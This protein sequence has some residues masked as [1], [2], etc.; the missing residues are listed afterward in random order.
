[1]PNWYSTLS[2]NEK[3]TFWA[4]YGGW[5]LDALD[6]QMLPLVLP[7]IMK[8]WRVSHTGAGSIVSASL[9][10]S[11]LGGWLGGALADRYGRV[12]VLQI[13]VI[14][15]SLFSLLAAVAQSPAQLA[16]FK[17]LQGLG[18]GGE[19][20]V[21]AVLVAEVFRPQHRGKALGTIQSGWAVGW[22]ISVLLFTILSSF[23][24]Q[25]IC[26]RV[27]FVLGVLPAL[28]VL[29]IQRSIPEP[30]NSAA[31]LTDDGSSNR[32]T[33]R[34]TMFHIFS[35]AN[36]RITLIGALL[37]L[38]AHGGYYAFTTWLP[39]Y[40]MIERHIPLPAAGAYLGMIIVSFWCGCIGAAYL[41]DK[42]GRRYTI[43]LFSLG[44][45]A[46][47]T[48]YLLMHAT[49][50]E[51]FYLG[52]PL[53]FCSA[54]IPASMGAL[55]SEMF[56]AGIRGTGVGFCY[57]F[58]RIVSSGFPALVGVLSVRF[59][60]RL[61]IGMDAVA[62]YAIVAIAVLGLPETRQSALQ[63]ERLK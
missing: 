51:M 34:M 53:G 24:P 47:I 44:S 9:A 21:G 11:A 3:H 36:L 7:A 52:F 48:L 38:G 4:C 20:A 10:C 17:G 29:Y 6:A 37:G 43:L 59:G 25:T 27:L 32:T 49:T 40:L 12:R 45:I 54:G 33:L 39:T 15:F 62:G 56:P 31:L 16:L 18:F 50:T 5:S 14:C 1:M 42:I 23:L 35:P 58:G 60:L 2:Q 63:S 41:L 30:S 8:N 28:L 22:G 61:A 55:F 19:W 26:W 13:T 57:N 46:T